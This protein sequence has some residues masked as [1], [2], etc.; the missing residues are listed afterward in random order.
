MATHPR[1][2]ARIATFLLAAAV[3]LAGCG[4][5]C[6][7]P[8]RPRRSPAVTPKPTPLIDTAAGIKIA[9]ASSRP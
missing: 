3:V 5:T 4:A 1:S 9:K 2:L 6:P 8:R 7:E